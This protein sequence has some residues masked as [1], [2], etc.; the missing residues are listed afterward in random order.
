M[1]FDQTYAEIN[2]MFKISVAA[3]MGFVLSQLPLSAEQRQWW[4][5]GTPA[6][7]NSPRNE[8]EFI[9]KRGCNAQIDGQFIWFPSMRWYS[10]YMTDLKTLRSTRGQ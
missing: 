4:Q 2:S 9:Q 3:L 8:V 7:C 10:V 6:T 5:Y 1:L